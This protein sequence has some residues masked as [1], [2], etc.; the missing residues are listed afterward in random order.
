MNTT[1]TE[2]CKA[3]PPAAKSRSERDGMILIPASPFLMGSETGGEFER[4]VHEVFLDE[5]WM[6]ETLVTNRQFED[7][8]QQTGYVTEAE[9]AGQAWGYQNGKFS[10]APGLSWR[11][12]ALPER[13]EHPVLPC[14]GM[15][16][17]RTPVGP[18]NVSPRKRSGRKRSEAA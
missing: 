6:D 12:Y 9:Q 13:H 3:A 8:V 7:F 14:H 2:P 11:S 18:A 16:R 4:P 15:T 10:S 17:M 5:F 1:L